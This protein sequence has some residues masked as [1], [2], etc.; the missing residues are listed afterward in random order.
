MR[1]MTVNSVLAALLAGV[2]GA[3]SGPSSSAPSSRTLVVTSYEYTFQAPDSLA[4]GVVTVRLVNRGRIGHQLS[5][6]RLDDSA[7]LAR[8]MQSLVADKAHTVGVHWSGGVESVVA[9]ESAETTMALRPGRY[10]LVCEFDAG[11]GHAHVS[12]GMIRP[13]L[14][15]GAASKSDTT[16]PATSATVRLTDYRFTLTGKLHVGRQLVRVQNDGSHRHHLNL[17]RIVGNA[18]LEQIDKW[19]GKSQPSPLDDISGGASVL[20]PGSAS[21][22]ALDLKPGRYLLACV[23]T[24]DKDSKPHYML[25][26]E[27]EITIK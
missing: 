24:D 8:V 14:V 2:P 3:I 4:A 12:M 7:S 11:N 6:A 17:T 22:I 19:D 21:V 23:L 5:F 18:T 9:G 1:K 27:K 25:G 26:M 10:I 16:L 15:T 20:D 13:L